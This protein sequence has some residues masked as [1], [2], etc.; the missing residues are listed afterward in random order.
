MH[1]TNKP[2]LPATGKDWLLPFYD[3]LTRLFG[4][5]GFHKELIRQAGIT[6]GYRVLEIGYGTGSLAILVKRQNPDVD[7]VG[8]DPDP[9][10]LARARQKAQR[11]R[12]TLQFDSGFSEKLPYPNASFDRMLSAFMFHHISPEGKPLTLKEA[13]RLLKPGG[14]LHLLD[15][16][17][18]QQPGSGLHGMLAR[19]AHSGHGA[20]AQPIVLRLMQ[21]AGF[22]DSQVVAHGST[23]IGRIVYYK[24]VRPSPFSNP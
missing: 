10:A 19:I 22:K 13:Y 1:S 11:K 12:L 14:S 6:P 16:E 24:A 9:G 7:V 3:P 4:V 15:F 18:T 2:Y 8:I 17:E 21:E 5:E 23:I 20:S